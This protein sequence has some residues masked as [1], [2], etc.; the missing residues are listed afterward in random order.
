MSDTP[1]PAPQDAVTEPTQPEV[2]SKKPPLSS[3][4]KTIKAVKNL[5]LFSNAFFH[6]CIP[7]LIIFTVLANSI[8]AGER[9]TTAPLTL[10]V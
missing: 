2:E 9:D 5:S 3:A 10:A 4:K 1:P 8:W 6:A 7:P